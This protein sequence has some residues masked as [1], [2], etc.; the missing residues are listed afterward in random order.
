MTGSK[1]ITADED[2]NF[3]EDSGDARSAWFFDSSAPVVSLQEQAKKA[4]NIFLKSFFPPSFGSASVEDIEAAKHLPPKATTVETAT[5]N[6]QTTILAATA[7]ESI[8]D[9]TKN[10]EDNQGTIIASLFSNQGNTIVK[11][12]TFQSE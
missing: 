9:E 5:E 1:P 7:M 2:E 3:G 12:R 6:E 8:T 10:A 4:T 11:E